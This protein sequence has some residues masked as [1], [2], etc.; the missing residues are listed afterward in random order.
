MPQGS[1]WRATIQRTHSASR[2]ESGA[3]LLS[4]GLLECACRIAVAGRCTRRQEGRWIGGTTL[5]CTHTRSADAG[6]RLAAA[7]LDANSQV[8]QGIERHRA[9]T[10]TI[11]PSI[12]V[13]QGP[14]GARTRRQDWRREETRARDVP[15]VKAT[16]SLAQNT[17]GGAAK[18]LQSLHIPPLLHLALLPSYILDTH[19]VFLRILQSA[20]F[21]GSLV[22]T[23]VRTVLSVV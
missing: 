14:A 9:R 22:G 11:C 20:P 4:A 5:L 12:L 7:R 15:E 21:P 16:H 23:S 8:C 10:A 2:L 1:D 3:E 19:H 18:H 13:R 6:S 17:R